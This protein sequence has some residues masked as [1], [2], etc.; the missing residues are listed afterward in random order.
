METK[1][2][3]YIGYLNTLE[4]FENKR[5]AFDELSELKTKGDDLATPCLL[6]W[7]PSALLPQLMDLTDS[8]GGIGAVTSHGNSCSILKVST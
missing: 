6:T 5:P 7:S 3:V 4:F 1:K 2:D 8:V